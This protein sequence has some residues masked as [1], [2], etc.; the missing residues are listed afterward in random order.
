M[1]WDKMTINLSQLD[2]VRS[3]LEELGEP[4]QESVIATFRGAGCN[5]P[6][7]K[8]YELR[9]LQFR[10]KVIRE[11]VTMD[12]DCDS[13]DYIQSLQFKLKD[14]PK[15]WTPIVRIQDGVCECGRL[16]NNAEFTVCFECKEG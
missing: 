16:I 6:D 3:T 1:S 10:D 14:E 13:N 4:Y 8:M 5:D 12:A 9:R 11:C 15:H 2:A 7:G